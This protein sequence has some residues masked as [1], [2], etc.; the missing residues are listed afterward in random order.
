MNKKLIL[1]FLYM[2]AFSVHSQEKIYVDK[3]LKQVT[4]IENAAFYFTLENKKSS[5][6]NTRSIYYL[7]GHRAAIMHFSNYPKLV[8]DGKYEVWYE[9]GEIL[10]VYNFSDGIYN[11]KY[12][13][14]YK[15]GNYKVSKTFL[16]GK[17]NGKCETWYENGKVSTSKF[18]ADGKLEGKY[19]EWYDNGNM[20]FSTIY[21][22]GKLNGDLNSWFKSGELESTA[23]Y[24]DD[25]EEGIFR[26]YYYNCQKKRIDNYVNGK[27]IDGKCF[28]DG[29]KE[30]PYFLYK[31]DPSYPGGKSEFYKYIS[32]NFKS[33]NSGKGKILIKFYVDKNGTVTDVE[34]LKGINRDLDKEAIRV[35]KHSVQ[36]TPGKIDGNYAGIFYTLPLTID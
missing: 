14:W 19:E 7:S 11:G 29:G 9:T 26:L 2:V 1:I 34:I 20:Q 12:E 24:I 21:L 16:D 3:D 32:E 25:K 10:S 30:I 27:L 4:K 15:N 36:W 28:D 35:V 5:R 31:I 13:E 18:Y 23:N 22:D 8:A 17:L 6:I 33:P